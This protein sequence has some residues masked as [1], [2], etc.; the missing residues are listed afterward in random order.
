MDIALPRYVRDSGKERR[1]SSVE[2]AN[3]HLGLIAHRSWPQNLSRARRPRP[4]QGSALFRHSLGAYCSS[5]VA[6]KYIAGETPASPARIRII[7]TFPK[8]WLRVFCLAVAD[9]TGL[10]VRNAE[11]AQRLKHRWIDKPVGWQ[12]DTSLLIFVWQF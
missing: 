8:S 7:Q 5:L 11:V 4:R 10:V 6:A 2:L 1:A 9:G 12:N 3:E